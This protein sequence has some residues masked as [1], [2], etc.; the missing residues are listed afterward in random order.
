MLA[1][2]PIRG[3]SPFS[4]SAFPP[5]PPHTYFQVVTAPLSLTLLIVGAYSCGQHRKVC[6]CVCVRAN[7]PTP[8]KASLSSPTPLPSA[9]T[10]QLTTRMLLSEY[11]LCL[12]TPVSSLKS[13]DS[14]DKM[15]WEGGRRRGNEA[16]LNSDD[17]RRGG[18]NLYIRASIFYL[19][20]Y[21]FIHAFPTFFIFFPAFHSKHLI[22]E[23]PHLWF[24]RNYITSHLS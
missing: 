22:P 15:C 20:F 4:M 18:D 8:E 17:N 11:F 7:V 23:G 24:G 10:C 1:R 16:V 3:S 9:F 19:L 14:G 6:V 12:P 2:R 21:L 13:G 5:L